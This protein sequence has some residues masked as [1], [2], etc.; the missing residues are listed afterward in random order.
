MP[1]GYIPDLSLIVEQNQDILGI[2]E[3][4]ILKAPQ[5]NA[6]ATFGEETILDANYLPF[7]T[8][9]GYPQI[10]QQKVRVEAKPCLTKCKVCAEGYVLDHE[11]RECYEG[12]ECPFPLEK[13]LIGGE[14][15][16]F[17][18]GERLKVQIIREDKVKKEGKR[19]KRKRR[20]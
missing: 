11:T 2:Q 19:K 20:T 15:Q 12:N 10:N 9:M 3:D 5:G 17:S 13:A 8:K 7:C 4:W 18:V 1:Q 16:C 14:Y 6:L